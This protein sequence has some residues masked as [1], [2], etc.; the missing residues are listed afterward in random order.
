MKVCDPTNTEWGFWDRWSDGR[1]EP[2]TKATIERF[3]DGGTFVDIGAWIGPTALWAAEHAER[4]VAIEPDPTAYEML[5][6]NTS[7]LAVVERVHV[8]VADFDGTT[9]ISTNGDSMSR[10]GGGGVDVACYTLESLFARLGVT[11]ADLIKMDIEGAEREV[12]AQA[13]PF[14]RRFGAPMLLSLHA[15]A[16]WDRNLL[17]GW[18]VEQL[19]PHEFVVIP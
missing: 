16:P 5:E 19:E 11:S 10:I 12:L 7:E 2:E 3:C 13:E 17:P 15:W 8:A 14:L 4:V 1:W 18:S 9:T 6:V